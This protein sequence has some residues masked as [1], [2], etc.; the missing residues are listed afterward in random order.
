[1]N[2]HYLPLSVF[3]LF[4]LSGCATESTQRYQY[5]SEATMAEGFSQK[6]EYKQAASLYQSLAESKPS[7][8]NEFKLLAA[9]A[10]IQSGDSSSAQPILSSINPNLLSAKQ[11]NQLNLIFVQIDLSHGNTEQALTKLGTTQAYN[12]DPADQIIFYQ[13][14]AF[15]HSLS[16]SPLKSAQARIQLS[17]HLE[18][19]E[20]RNENN[21]VILNT[22]SS[23]PSQTLKF[24]Q[25][26]APKTLRGW[27]ALAI[28]L[29][30]NGTQQNSMQFQLQLSEWQRQYPHHPATENF[31]QSYS[32]GVSNTYQTANS[33]AILLPESGRFAKAAE[34]IKAGFMAAYHKSEIS[35]QPSIRSYDSSQNNIVNLYHQAVADGAEL[36][37][38]PLIKDNIEEL[39]LS[40]DLTT[41]VLALNH[42]T[43]LAKDNLFQFG[44][45]PLDDAKQMVNRASSMGIER[46]LILTP[47]SSHGHRVAEYLSEYWQESNGSVLET[48]HYKTR[49]SDFSESIKSL[50]NI[51]ESHTRHARLK[52][53]LAIDLNFT[54]RRRHDVE[55][56][57]LSASAQKA[58]SIYPQLQFYRAVKVPVYALP[59][60]YTGQPNP[61]ADIDLNNINF[62]DIPWVF[63][64]IFIGDLSKDLLHDS[65][66]DIPS[67]YL[68]LF[69]MGLD[70]FNIASNLENI[71]STPFP[72]A[73]GT[74]SINKENRITRKLVCAKFIDGQ[75]I[76]QDPIILEQEN[77]F[78]S[79]EFYH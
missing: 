27:M 54:E 33:L 8:K 75:A 45:S 47:E 34:A 58:R 63:P 21:T 6:G 76:T 37:I 3:C 40:T 36:I 44:L 4:F 73:T 79:E 18:S 68:R 16:G 28:L 59:Q 67:R 46:A 10:L 70:S 77:T 49:G 66:R 9:Q 78:E 50:L 15:A 11:R 19:A 74:L 23:I 12:L 42:V 17:S 7:Q 65:W 48:Q 2:R 71:A 52:R 60:V 69:A 64:N 13:S 30:D 29:Q 26:S 31:I 39:A 41:P 24:H 38:G 62:C 32:K 25:S 61:S 22:L 43:N 57:F 35:N 53:Y 56:I 1:M 55:A 20:Q 14:L 72:G 51:D 5:L